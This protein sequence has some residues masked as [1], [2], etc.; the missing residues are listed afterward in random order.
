MSDRH[1]TPRLFALAATLVRNEGGGRMAL[2]TCVAF[3]IA[4]D[5]EDAVVGRWVQ[6]LL[7]QNPGFALI[8][9]VQVIGVT[10]EDLKAMGQADG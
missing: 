7:E 4:T 9:Q 6:A 3:R 2:A 8:N 5:G 1:S 10:R